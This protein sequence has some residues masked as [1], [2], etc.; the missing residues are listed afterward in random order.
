MLLIIRTKYG[1][2]PSWT[3]DGTERT[4]DAGRTDGRTDGPFLRMTDGR[5]E[6]NQYTPNKFVVWRAWWLWVGWRPFDKRFFTPGRKSAFLYCQFW[7]L[8]SQNFGTSLDSND[9]LVKMW[10]K[11]P[12]G[13][14][15]W[16]SYR[17]K[18]PA[19][20][21]FVQWRVKTY[22]TLHYWL[23]VWRIFRWITYDQ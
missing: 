10:M 16:S 21:L 22:K 3:V 2:N 11:Y 8:H 5:T 13:H 15:T 6:W 4:R 1:K 7:L 9:V 18:S 12:K 20:R 19:I 14:I 17:V 23:S